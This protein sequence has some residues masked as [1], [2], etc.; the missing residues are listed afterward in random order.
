M[1]GEGCGERASF[2]GRSV[3]P[4][5]VYERLVAAA[6]KCLESRSRHDWRPEAHKC[7]KCDWCDV[8]QGFHSEGITTFAPSSLQFGV[9]RM[10]KSIEAIEFWIH[11]HRR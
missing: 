10:T 2:S 9:E 7:D 3:V 4:K 1:D 11:N 6:S 8:I 5:A